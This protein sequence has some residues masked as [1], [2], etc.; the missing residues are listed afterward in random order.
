MATL[1]VQKNLT[2]NRQVPHFTHTRKLVSLVTL[3]HE[4]TRAFLGSGRNNLISLQRII[5]LSD[6]YKCNVKINVLGTL[7]NS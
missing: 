1:R 4:I 6:F 3:R 5:D 7:E 2:E